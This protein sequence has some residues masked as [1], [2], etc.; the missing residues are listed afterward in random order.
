MD[1][2]LGLCIGVALAAACGMRVFAPLLI[3]SLGA[4]AGL[5]P[6]GESFAWLGTWGATIALGTATVVEFGASSVPWVEHALDAVASPA[7]IIAG[8]LLAASQLE[9]LPPGA[10]WFLA[11]IAGGGAAGLTQAAGVTTRGAS[12]VTTAGLLNPFLNAVQSIA[13]LVVSV[14]AVVVPVL[15]AV[16]VLT[17]AVVVGRWWWRRRAKRLHLGVPLA[18]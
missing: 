12:T 14:V 7:A 18:A 16:L 15:A 5:V 8:T 17:T 4:H 9:H 10:A 3:V 1:T 11:L 13:S 6:L 2:I